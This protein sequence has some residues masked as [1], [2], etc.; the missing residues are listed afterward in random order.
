MIEH[1]ATGSYMRV[2]GN[3][4]HRDL[5]IIHGQVKSNW[6]RKQGH[7]LDTEDISD[8]LSA[9][10]EML[11]IGTGYAGNMR[12]PDS[13]RSAIENHH[14]RVV[15]EETANAVSIFNRLN[16][17]GRDVAGAFHLTC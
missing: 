17:E 8:I 16:H 11:V 2:D 6:W 1:Y 7:R 15:A 10:P 5:K 9:K 4:Y 14:I 3:D 12:I 13:V